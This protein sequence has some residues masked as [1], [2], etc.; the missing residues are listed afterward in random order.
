MGAVGKNVP[1]DSAI[2]H[3]SG[4][5]IYID[6]MP[7]SHGE[8]Q[9]DFFWSPFAHAR[10]RSIDVA[11]ALKVPGIAG[12]YTYRDPHANR[13]GPIIRDELLLAED[14]AT[15]IG[16]PIVVI[17]A[18]TRDALRAAKKAIRVEFEELKPV[19]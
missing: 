16:M 14:L 3:V 1:H 8:L 5:S 13:F 9:V 17:A 2:G 4:R 6:D 19:L 12:L 15:F 18:E 7:P 11:E 10:I